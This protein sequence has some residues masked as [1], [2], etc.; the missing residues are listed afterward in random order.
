MSKVNGF[1]S[2]T[3][4]RYLSQTKR[5]QEKST[6]KLA[7]G[8]RIN[9]ASDDAASL[10]ISSKLTATVRSKGQALRN[11]NDAISIVQTIE[12]GLHDFSA[13]IG[14][15]R[16]LAVQAASANYTPQ[17][18]KMLD[19]EL[20][21]GLLQINQLA[22]K[23]EMFGQKLAVGNS[24]KLQIQVDVNNGTGNRIEIDLENLSH[25]TAALGV[26][27]IDIAS[28]RHAQLAIVQIDYAM[29]EVS[30]SMARMGAINSRLDKA[31]NKLKG[32]VVTTSQ[33][34]SKIKDTDYAKE[35][36]ENTKN[37]IVQDGQTSV[38]AQSNDL[39]KSS[40]KLIDD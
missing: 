15:L 17:E 32:D 33:A 3:G 39:L 18:R 19:M 22:Q 23:Q 10:G 14:H 34:N 40:L 11:A 9:S 31:I 20:Q 12:A 27:D 37:K 25:T 29:K 13:V 21:Q 28:Q 24:R 36:A 4:Q 30:K 8:N 6:Q 38:V 2:F 5:E 26:N 1:N 16:Q 35:T 7:T